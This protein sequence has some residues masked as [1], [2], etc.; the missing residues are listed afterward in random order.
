MIPDRLQL[1]VVFYA[2]LFCDRGGSLSCLLELKR[3][4]LNRDERI[5]II[6]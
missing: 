1:G 2:Q 4:G 6:Y 3:V 5:S